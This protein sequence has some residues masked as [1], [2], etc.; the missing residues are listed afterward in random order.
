MRLSALTQ[1]AIVVQS[2]PDTDA[3]AVFSLDASRR[4]DWP[5]ILVNGGAAIQM[6]T[7]ATVALLPLRRSV[8]G[9]GPRGVRPP[10]TL[11]AGA[12]TNAAGGPSGGVLQA[13]QLRPRYFRIT[14]AYGVPSAPTWSCDRVEGEFDHAARRVAVS[15]TRE[16]GRAEPESWQA[17][18]KE[19]AYRRCWAVV[20]ATPLP[21]NPPLY[22]GG[23][24]I[25]IV[26]A[27]GLPHEGTPANYADWRDLLQAIRGQRPGRLRLPWNRW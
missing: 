5:L 15:F 22:G 12:T 2:G 25:A 18:F 6:R 20:G 13:A 17:D 9:P 27:A 8:T 4:R 24:Q 11:R 21:L 23:V 7:W 19:K 10:A 1:R 16:R 3:R 26:D 14:L